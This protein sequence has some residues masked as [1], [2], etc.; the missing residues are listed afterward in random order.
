MKRTLPILL[1]LQMMFP[2]NRFVIGSDTKVYLQSN[3]KRTPLREE[4]YIL[5]DKEKKLKIDDVRD[6]PVASN[7]QKRRGG[8]SNFDYTSSAYWVHF[9]VDNQTETTDFSLR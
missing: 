9:I 4:L 3:V 1:F 5:E 7:Y 8:I 2:I 6:D